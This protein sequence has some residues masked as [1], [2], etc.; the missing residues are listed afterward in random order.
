[1]K[2]RMLAYHSLNIRNKRKPS[3]SRPLRSRRGPGRGRRVSHDEG[4]RRERQRQVWAAVKMSWSPLERL[5]GR[6]T[7]VCLIWGALQSGTRGRRSP[8]SPAPQGLSAESPRTRGQAPAVTCCQ[9]EPGSRDLDHNRLLSCIALQVEK[10]FS[11][12]FFRDRSLT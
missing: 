2:L 6:C 9:E 12:D 11:R 10:S 8:R 5:A 1:M 4:R 3:M 7:L